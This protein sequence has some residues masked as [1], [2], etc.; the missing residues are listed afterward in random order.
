M[1][2]EVSLQLMKLKTILLSL[3]SM[4]SLTAAP[5]EVGGKLPE[6]KGMNQEGKEVVIQ[7]ADGNQWLLIFTYPKALTGG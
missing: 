5:L 3:A 1:G 6:L 7:A 4:L 2:K